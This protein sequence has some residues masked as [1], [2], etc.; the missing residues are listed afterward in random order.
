MAILLWSDSRCIHELCVCVR[1]CQCLPG[2]FQVL[3]C[4]FGKIWQLS[5]IPIYFYCT[6]TF[7]WSS[8]QSGLRAPVSLARARIWRFICLG[9]ELRWSRSYLLTQIEQLQIYPNFKCFLLAFS[10]SFR[11]SRLMYAKIELS[12]TRNSAMRVKARRERVGCSK[13][14]E[15]TEP[16]RTECANKKHM[17]THAHTSRITLHFLCSI[18]FHSTEIWCFYSL[19][20]WFASICYCSVDDVAATVV[21]VVCVD[22]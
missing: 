3:L 2:H 18:L 1:V 16:S 5:N 4:T 9:S 14:N 13:Q 20:W 11:R 19:A 22:A 17:H 6:R 7:D 12:A 21:V 8:T 15:R 10:G